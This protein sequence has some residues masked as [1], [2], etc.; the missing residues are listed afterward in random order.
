MA[1]CGVVP[2]AVILLIFPSIVHISA[3]RIYIEGTLLLHMGPNWDNNS[4][5][6]RCWFRSSRGSIDR[7][8]KHP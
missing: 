4:V 2:V 3:I 5:E 7:A 1:V 8:F 6:H